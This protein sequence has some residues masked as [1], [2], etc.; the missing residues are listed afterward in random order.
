MPKQCQN[1]DSDGDHFSLLT[2][3][4]QQMSADKPVA[5]SL[6]MLLLLSAQL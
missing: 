2:E 1:D 4:N 5:A 6:I 3:E